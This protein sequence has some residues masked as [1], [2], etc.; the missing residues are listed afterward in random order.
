MAESHK[1]IESTLLVV[2]KYFAHFWD[3]V[4]E[5][6]KQYGASNDAEHFVLEYIKLELALESLDG[7]LK[8]KREISQLSKSK[9]QTL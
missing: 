4:R 5:A 9:R 7:K 8:S 6:R 3:V 2:T 1:T